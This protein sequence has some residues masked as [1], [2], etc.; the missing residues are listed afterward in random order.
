M[1]LRQL[2]EILATV[3]SSSAERGV[4]GTAEGRALDLDDFDGADPWEGDKNQV[5][6]RQKCAKGFRR[7]F[8]PLLPELHDSKLLQIEN[9]VPNGSNAVAFLVRGDMMRG[10]TELQQ[11]VVASHLLNAIAPLEAA[12]FRVD[13]FASYYAP[14]GISPAEVLSWYDHGKRRVVCSS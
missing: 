3:C 8:A 12:G 13:V 9:K 10:G 2:F 6:Q 5:E 11:I 7:G 1:R 14:K 4:F